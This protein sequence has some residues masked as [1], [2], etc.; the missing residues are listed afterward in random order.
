LV[1]NS[2]PLPSHELLKST[3]V[4]AGLVLIGALLSGSVL[5][6]VDKDQRTPDKSPPGTLQV[7]VT[8]PPPNRP[9]LETDVS[10]ALYTQ[11]GELFK[12]IGYKE[13]IDEVRSHE[14]PS[15]DCWPVKID[16]DKWQRNVIRNLE[17][18]LRRNAADQQGGENP[19]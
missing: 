5:H 7:Q 14:A 9:L 11:I 17:C 13:P 1:R 16:L 19:R 12:R 3:A 8:I 2:Q 18:C 6:A 4:L 15:P 10:D